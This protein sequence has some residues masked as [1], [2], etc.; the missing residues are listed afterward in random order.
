MALRTNFSELSDQELLNRIKDN[1]DHLGL[2]YNKCKSNSINFMK[3]MTNGTI[4][5]YDYDDVFQDAII[6]LYEKIKKGNFVLTSSFQ[7]YLNS[8]CRFQVLNTIDKNKLNSNY[9]DDI[10]EDED[11]NSQYLTSIIDNLDEIKYSKEPLFIAIERALDLMKNSGGKCYDLLT[12]FWYKERSMQEL[13]EIFE[14]TNSANTKNQKARC[15]E[16]LRVMANNEL[17]SI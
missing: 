6:I 5:G 17:N 7:T 15:Q 8:V 12:Q 10:N 13:T 14:Y 11:E 3:K 4:N 1:V 2:V 16:K 9:L